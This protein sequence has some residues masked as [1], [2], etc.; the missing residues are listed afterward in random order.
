MSLS[1]LPRPAVVLG[2]AGI[3]PQAGCLFAT[4]ALPAWHWFAVAAGCFY[5]ALILSFLGGLWWMQALLRDDHRWQPYLFG[6]VVSLTGW[7]ALL[8]WCFGWSWPQPALIFLGLGLIA[9]PLVDRRLSLELPVQASWLR[10][11]VIMATGL[12]VITIL[13]GLVTG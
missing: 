13:L 11:R 3:L 5:A 1:S 9:S 12:G 2:L 7:G 6:V 4:S 8:P 10:L